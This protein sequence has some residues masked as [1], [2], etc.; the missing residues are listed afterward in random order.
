MRGWELGATSSAS[1]PRT[2]EAVLVRRRH[3][4]GGVLPHATVDAQCIGL[5]R[6][7]VGDPSVASSGLFSGI[8]FFNFWLVRGSH[9]LRCWCT[10]CVVQRIEK[11]ELL[12]FYFACFSTKEVLLPRARRL[13]LFLRRRPKLIQKIMEPQ[14]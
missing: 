8:S 13:V 1:R 10:D 14:Y 3:N 2:L 12:C 4:G 7:P 9:V 11:K 5:S 6:R